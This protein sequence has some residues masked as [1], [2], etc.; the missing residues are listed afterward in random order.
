M[1]RRITNGGRKVIGKFPSQK[2]RR[3]VMWES[4]IERDY[5]YLLEFDPA[6]ISFEEQSVCV[7]YHD[8]RDGKIHR[9]TP[10]FLVTR[11]GNRV[12]VVEIKDDKTAESDDCR[13]LFRR[14]APII[15]REG[16]EFM[17]VTDSMIRVQPLLDNVK[18]LQKYST[19]R[20]SDSHLLSLNDI[21]SNRENI[22]F[23]E[24][25]HLMGLRG[26]L[27]Q[28]VFA[29]LRHGILSMDFHKAIDDT[30][31]VSCVLNSRKCGEEKI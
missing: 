10:D 18:L 9:Y 5:I 1:I 3:M 4:Q 19:I 11:A 14:V 20:I 22:P 26:I 2:M 21:L 7:R 24:I 6:V 16:Y 25:V 28:E 23:G 31:M 15:C 13:Q 17:V 27:K 30:A 12:Q 29:L 8:D